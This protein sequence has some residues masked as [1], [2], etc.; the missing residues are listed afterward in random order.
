[1]KLSIGI[2][3]LNEEKNIAATI[4]SALN[5]AAPWNSEVILADSHSTDQTVEIAKKFPIEILKL[6]DP[7]DRSPGAGAQIAFEHSIGDYFMMLDGDMILDETFINNAISYLEENLEVAG[8]GGIIEEVNID[9][10]QYR[11]D[12]YKK[13]RLSG[14]TEV[15]SLNGGGMY[16]RAAI[17]DVGYFSNANLRSYEELELGIRL[18]HRGWKLV[19]IGQRSTKHFGHKI[20]SYKLI[21][22]RLQ[23]GYM[24]GVGQIVRES[25]GTQYFWRLLSTFRHLQYAI[26]VILWMALLFAVTA[27]SVIFG[28]FLLPLL[29]LL[30]AVPV[31]YLAIRRNSLPGGV[32]SLFSWG[33]LAIGLLRGVLQKSRRPRGETPKYDLIMSQRIRS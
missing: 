26:I 18:L 33:A 9:N 23:T 7:E 28:A 20:G 24:N 27:I 1:M 3:A 13:N 32:F 10:Y 31:L 6:V 5:G 8:V 15:N 19:N 25:I 2:K 12:H 11:F 16:R 14:T 29:F 30:I 17:L 4:E 21:M 22:R